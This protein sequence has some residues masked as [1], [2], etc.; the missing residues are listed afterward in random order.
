MKAV[1]ALEMMG[2]WRVRE[3]ES[4]GK[5]EEGEEWWRNPPLERRWRAV[6]CMAF[7]ENYIRECE[8]RGGRVFQRGN[9]GSGEEENCRG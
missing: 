4:E 2:N 6:S 5:R 1:L 7:M 9:Q 3:R 8:W